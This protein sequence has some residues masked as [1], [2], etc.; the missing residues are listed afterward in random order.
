V[1]YF[2]LP[3][4]PPKTGDAHWAH[5]EDLSTE[6]RIK[7]LG[8]IEPSQ[9]PDS[10]RTIL[11]NAKQL[12]GKTYDSYA[13]LPGVEE[14]EPWKVK[15]KYQAKLLVDTA[16]RCRQRNESSWRYACEPI[17]MGRLSSEVCW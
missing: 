9:W 2:T 3:S 8:E 6:Y 15:I 17:I 10:H 14:S 16:G 11:Q 7:F 4:M 5:L 13:T 1:L 12:G